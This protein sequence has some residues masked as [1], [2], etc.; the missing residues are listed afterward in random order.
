M[1]EKSMKSGTR[2]GTH[3]N[4]VNYSRMESRRGYSSTFCKA[5]TWIR[6]QWTDDV[7]DCLLIETFYH[8]FLQQKQ[9]SSNLKFKILNFK[10]ALEVLVMNEWYTKLNN[11]V[12]IFFFLLLLFRNKM[13]KISKIKFFL[14][15][16]DNEIQK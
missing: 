14:L 11:F 9:L 1:N 10:Q 8:S 5:R 6:I 15:C 3:F 2:Y 4:F 13:T 7:D 16:D 12:K